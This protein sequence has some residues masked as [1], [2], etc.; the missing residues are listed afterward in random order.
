MDR[1]EFVEV[2]GEPRAQPPAPFERLAQPPPEKDRGQSVVVRDP[3]ERYRE[4]PGTVRV[5]RGDE[6]F[7]ASRLQGAAEAGD[8]DTR[9]AV[10][11]GHGRND[12]QHPNRHG[13]RVAGVA[14]A[15]TAADRL[16]ALRWPMKCPSRFAITRPAAAVD[17]TSTNDPP[18]CN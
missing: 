9:T 16:R 2:G 11:C 6:R 3:F 18:I 15:S 5:R 8:S 4:S 17:V 1:V 10:S 7:D 14:M 13:Y 12:V